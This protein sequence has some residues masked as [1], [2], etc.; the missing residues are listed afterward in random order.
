[1]VSKAESDLP[2]SR[3]IRVTV[4]GKRIVMPNVLIS[5]CSAQPQAYRVDNYTQTHNLLDYFYRILNE[6]QHKMAS[7][8]FVGIF[9]CHIIDQKK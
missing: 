2:S 6:T 5:H 1:M 9:C 4:L 3:K 7:G 8:A